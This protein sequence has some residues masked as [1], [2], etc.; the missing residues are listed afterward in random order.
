MSLPILSCES[1]TMRFGGLLAINNLSFSLQAGNIHGLIGPNGAGKTTLFNVISGYYKPNSGRV[2]FQG[3]NI[4]G[5]KMHDIAKR[6]LT[7]TFQHSSLFNEL[8]VLENMLIGFYLQQKPTL[9][10]TI[11]GDRGNHRMRMVKKAEEL[12][13]FFNLF[14]RRSERAEELPYGM[15]RALGVAV[16]VASQPKVLM[17]DEPF[18]GINPEETERMM[19]LMRN[20]RNSGITLLLV[21]HDMRAV[22][23][24]CDTITV[25]NFGQVLVEGGADEIINHP[26]V[27]EAYLGRA[28]HAT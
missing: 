20:V 10:S 12:L 17:L 1:L 9:V 4:A 6:G 5:L 22:M 3:E 13:A 24:L 15:Q 16:A 23:G 27:I 2:L 25:I 28:K 18:T 8:T 14:D 19:E 26:Q 7:R 21:E 11:L